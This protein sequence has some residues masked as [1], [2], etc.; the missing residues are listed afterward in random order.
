LRSGSHEAFAGRRR[1]Q[2]RALAAVIVVALLAVGAAAQAETREARPAPAEDVTFVGNRS[3]SDAAL[4]QAARPE[5]SR[6]AD[7]GRRPADIDDAA[8][9]MEQAYRR[10]GYAFARVGYDLPAAGGGAVV[11]RV[12]EGPRVYVDR[13]A[14]T[15]NDAIDT[16][17]ILT[18]LR[19]E[20]AGLL[21]GG[22]TPFVRA[23]IEAAVS[24]LRDLYLE[25]GYRDAEVADPTFTFRDGD[26]LVDV[27]LAV[28]EG[29]AYRVRRLTIA[30]DPPADARER[31]SR[32]ERDVIGRPYTPRVDLV[33]R[34]EA[35]EILGTLGYPDATVTV[36][37]ATPEGPGPVDL[38]ATIASG[39]LVTI[40][41]VRVDGA[42]RTREEFILKRMK[43]QPGE[44][45]D[46]TLQNESYAELF[47]TGI[48]RRLDIALEPTGD[49]G[50]RD[51][52]VRVDEADTREVYLEPGYGSYEGPRARA[53]YRQKNLFGSAIGWSSELTGSIKYQSATSTL[54]EPFFLDTDLQADLTAF[55]LRREEPAFTRRDHGGSFFVTRRISR[56]LILT[57]GYTLR[58]TDLSDL[59]AGVSAEDFQQN[60]DLSSIRVQATSDTR[61]DLLYPAEGQRTFAA[62][63]QAESWLG[64]DVNFTRITL[65]T[66]VF[67]PLPAAVVLGLRYDTGFSIPGR[68]DTTLPPPE[69]FSNGGEN[70]VR[71]FKEDR[72]GP[73]DTSGKPSGGLGYNV[74]SA[75]LRR[76]IYENLTGSLFADLGNVSPNRTR[77]EEGE[78]SYRSRQQLIADTLGDF[79]RNFRPAVGFGVQ[80]QLPV[81][82]VRMDVGFNPDRNAKRDEDLYVI[83]FSLGMAF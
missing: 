14:V 36:D 67:F 22:R 1:L 73:R 57:S 11:F 68:G 18:L 17:T 55:A 62:V 76:A 79:F 21:H 54:S 33:I 35:A 31:L 83:H 64:G 71:S 2:G 51:L 9:R 4:R 12:H 7:Q 26:S 20:H 77:Q 30:G 3:K 65:G 56:S 40:G 78:G 13:V 80:Y 61:N 72:L 16:P 15:G 23:E 69:R 29:E 39:P 28:R 46:L 44:R 66:R 49:P 58:S 45:Y 27:A 81:G 41:A 8:F 82:P 47:K 48:F 34:S 50:R 74:L 42:G 63:E 52:V 38:D 32:L 24:D 60:Y 75:E 19:G 53:G 25:R 43:L 10:D 6:Y 70:T 37:S 59:G 5:L